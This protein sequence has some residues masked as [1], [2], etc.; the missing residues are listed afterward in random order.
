MKNLIIRLSDLDM[1]GSYTY[2]DYLTRMV[3]NGG[4]LFC[5]WVQPDLMATCC[6]AMK[7]KP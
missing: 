1:N 5:N 6:L 7:S 2:A 4:K 3:R